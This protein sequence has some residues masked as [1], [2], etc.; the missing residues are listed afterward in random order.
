M[1]PIAEEMDQLRESL[2]YHAQKYYVE[3]APE[4]SDHEYDQMFYRLL[5]LEE[6]Y[7]EY[8]TPDSPTKRI[9]G[10]V[11]EKF[12]KVEHHI[13][14]GSLRDVF[15]FEELR[16]FLTKTEEALSP[17][18]ETPAY[19]V[20][21]KIDGLSVSLKYRNGLFYEGATRGNGFV[22]ENVTENLKTL[23]SVPL[24][25]R[26]PI[27][28]LEVRGEVFMPK[29]KF[30][31]LNERCE[32]EGKKCFA[33]PRN[34]AAGSLR[35]LNSKITASRRLDIFI[36]NVQDHQGMS[37]S[38]HTDSLNRLS[39]LGFQVIPKRCF[40]QNFEQI[41]AFIED[42]G[43]ERT[44]LPYDIDGVVIKIDSLKQRTLLGETANVP[45]W[46]VAYK[47]P[48]EVK[49]TRLLD[50]SVNVGRT[51]VLTPNAILEPVQLAGTTVSRATLHNADYIAS[52]DIRIGDMVYVQK[53]GDI[54]PEVL[55]ADFEARS[56]KE[57]PFS[58]PTVCPSC[59][60]AVYR[61]SDEIALRCTNSACPAQLTRNIEHFASRAAMNIDGLGE[62]VVKL[63]VDAGLLHSVADL[64][65]LQNSEIEALPR[66]GKKATANL[67]NAIERSKNAGLARLIYALGIRQVGQKAA[68]TLASEYRSIDA[69]ENATAEELSAIYDIGEVTANYIVNFFSHPE[70]KMILERLKNAGVQTRYEEQ[71]ESDVLNGLTFV[72]T[73][74][75]PQMSREEATEQIQKNGGKVSSSVSKKTSFVLAGSD[76]GSKLQKA[77]TLGIPVIDLDEF[78]KMIHK[79]E[80]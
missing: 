68:Q 63:L 58:M 3:D 7:P 12:E 51:G 74:T 20:E 62:A 6:K 45:K 41:R 64:Y 13:K 8:D 5:E 72:L 22:G 23:H 50:I 30:L 10:A 33:N 38:S 42:I 54:I 15:S 75:L 14:M 52:R 79:T 59:K 17:Y 9:G 2:R 18:Q 70:S 28:Y 34:A 67:I 43:K 26:E 69:L 31:Q 21:C 29:K 65:S 36:F 1:N 57:A 44:K 49:R 71:T 16:D 37:F 77:E 73:G 55:K 11:L 27:P 4:I 78:L 46:A 19:S 35:Q 25:L 47:F 61:S 40:A 24:K 32:S 56:G 60:E 48:P 53:A 66:M 39:D 76:A 80:E